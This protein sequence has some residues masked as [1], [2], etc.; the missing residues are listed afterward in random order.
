M[1]RT[2]LAMALMLAIIGIACG[3]MEESRQIGGQDAATATAIPS[4]DATS[5]PEPTSEPESTPEQDADRIAGNHCTDAR[6]DGEQEILRIHPD[7]DEV[8]FRGFQMDSVSADGKHRMLI[9]FWEPTGGGGQHQG[10]ARF[11]VNS[12]DCAIKLVEVKY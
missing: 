8:T 6:R 11:S 12:A 4:P 9:V 1:N 3:S 5:E 7:R 2:H 10:I